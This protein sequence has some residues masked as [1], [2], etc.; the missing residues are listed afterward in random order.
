M[1]KTESK[2]KA[3]IEL[4][5]KGSDEAVINEIKSL[6]KQGS[7]A[8]IPVLLERWNNSTN[9]T[10][11]SKIFELMI[12]LRPQDA[13]ENIIQAIKNPEFSERKN[14]LIS[15]LWQSSLDASE[16]IVDLLTIALEGDYMTVLEVSTVIESFDT[17]FNE[18]DVMEAIYQI[19]ERM[20]TEDDE[21]FR[22]M[23]YS[24]KQVISKLPLDE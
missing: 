5:Q 19:D 23:L 1:T 21:E 3:Q 2:V 6:R 8:L 10:L 24:L 4:L 22:N 12:D 18:Q 11:N 17:V 9:E 14:V 13:L 7:T 15:I 16:Y 20:E